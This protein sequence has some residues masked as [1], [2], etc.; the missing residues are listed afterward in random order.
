MLIA[1]RYEI[2]RFVTSWKCQTKQQK[3]RFQLTVFK[4]DG[5]DL[6]FVLL[7][8]TDAIDFFGQLLR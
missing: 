2:F 7:M 8:R 3:Y 5:D 1:F 4:R 6:V